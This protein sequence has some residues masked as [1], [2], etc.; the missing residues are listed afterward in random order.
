[1]EASVDQHVDSHSCSDVLPAVTILKLLTILESKVVEMFNTIYK[2]VVQADLF[3]EANDDLKTIWM[4]TQCSWLV[5]E[6]LGYLAFPSEIVPDFN[7][8][9]SRDSHNDWSLDATL[10]CNDWTSMNPILHQAL[11]STLPFWDNIVLTQ[12]EDCQLGAIP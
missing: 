11:K 8:L 7:G 4:N 5:L 3:L 10:H 12:G 1:M 2:D 6:I 9:I